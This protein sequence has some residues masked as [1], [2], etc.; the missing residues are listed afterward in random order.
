MSKQEI[1]KAKLLVMTMIRYFN[2]YIH[3]QNFP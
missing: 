2:F 1:G 3:N